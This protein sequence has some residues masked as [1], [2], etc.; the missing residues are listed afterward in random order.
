M[1]SGSAQGVLHPPAAHSLV[2]LQGL[3]PTL[4]PSADDEPAPDRVGYPATRATADG[5]H[6]HDVPIDEGDAQLCPGSIA[7]ATPQT[8]TMASPPAKLPGFGVDR[9]P[10]P[11][12][13]HCTP[14]HIHQVGAGSSLTER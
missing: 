13:T 8:F 4:R 2:V 7:T 1:A 11:A 9:P 5:S 14:A 10:I 12:V 3:R 6:V